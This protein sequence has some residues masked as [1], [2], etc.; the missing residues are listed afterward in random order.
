MPSDLVWT[1]LHLRHVQPA[2]A[3]G[4]G[5]A[6][7]TRPHQVP[8]QAGAGGRGRDRGGGGVPLP[9]E[10]GQVEGAVPVPRP[11]PAQ[12]RHLSGLPR[13]PRGHA[14]VQPRP[15]HARR[16]HGGSL[17]IE[18]AHTTTTNNKEDIKLFSVAMHNRKMLNNN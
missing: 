16:L 5:H 17:P 14:G 15:R 18:H 4:P 3:Q 11:A 7:R 6:P 1:E 10:A 2:A 9:H 8:A 12:P 13:V